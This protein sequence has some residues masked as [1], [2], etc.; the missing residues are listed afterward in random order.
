M[1]QEEIE[2]MTR[3]FDGAWAED[4]V[5]YVMGTYGDRMLLASSISIEDQVLTHMMLSR[6]PSA[7]IMT[8]DTGRLPQETYDAMQATMEKYGM[9]FEVYAPAADDLERFLREH[10]PNCF[11]QSVE[12]RKQCCTI[13]KVLPLSRAL[14]TVEAWITGLR[15][16]QSPETRGRLAPV[17]WDEAHG[18]LK[19]NPLSR[20]TTDDVWRYIKKNAI[21]YSLLFDRGHTSIGCAPCTRAVTPG[22]GIRAGRWWWE[23]PEHKECGLHLRSDI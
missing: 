20:W 12:L 21:P 2:N 7:R 23:N 8:L 1:K 10:G 6:S 18:I 4:I 15:Q 13:R 16:E 19:V 3:L 5:A 9:R 17:E 22:E 14:T 11:Y